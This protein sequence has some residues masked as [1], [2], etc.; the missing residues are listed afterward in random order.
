M[1]HRSEIIGTAEMKQVVPKD[2]NHV[3]NLHAIPNGKIPH[4]SIKKTKHS[5][6]STPPTSMKRR[7]DVRFSLKDACDST[8]ELREVPKEASIKEYSNRSVIKSGRQEY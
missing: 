4:P 5:G 1:R 7:L 6:T 2:I 3:I 8:A